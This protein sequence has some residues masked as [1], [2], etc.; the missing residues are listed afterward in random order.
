M[1]GRSRQAQAMQAPGRTRGSANACQTDIRHTDTCQADIR[2]HAAHAARRPVASRGVR[3]RVLGGLIAIALAA[4]P[5]LTLDAFAQGANGSQPRGAGQAEVKGAP[6]PANTQPPATRVAAR[7]TDAPPPSGPISAVDAR[8]AGDEQRTRLIIDLSRSAQ[9]RAFTLAEPYRV[10]VDLDDVT[11]TFGAGSAQ[12][13]R[14]LVKSYRYGVFAPGKARM[15]IDVAGPVAIDKAFVL[16]AVDDQPA[17]FVL[18]LVKTDAAAF[19]TTVATAAEARGAPQLPT[20][21]DHAA[22]ADPRPVIVLDPGHGG[23]DSGTS[24]A[25]SF[26]EKNI[27]LDVAQVLR[28]KLEASGR[29]RVVM[30]RTGD[31]FVA[32]GE[33]VRIARNN[34]AALLVSIHADALARDDGQARGA[35]VYTLSETASDAEAA[36]LAELENKADLIAG[37]NLSDESDEVAG[38]LFD[39]AQRETRN[40][41]ITFARNLVGAMKAVGKVHKTP[42]KSAGFRVLKAHD[43]P[44]VLVELGYMSSR[45]DLKLMI[46]DAW[47]DKLATTISS[48]IDDFFAPRLAGADPTGSISPR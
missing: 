31:T 23:I 9:F 4:G 32:L 17:R 30:T 18:D 48:S 39:L 8:L 44:S 5:A 43:V 21:Y 35:S 14:G 42:L 13:Q 46:S 10:I 38:I 26:A 47:R 37:I 11:F 36:H 33:R 3:A 7:L 20:V 29:Y 24:G 27:V 22:A 2:A 40:F 41:S 15:V 45:E 25:S 19:A 28:A 34:R 1:T 12:S 16:D 6:L